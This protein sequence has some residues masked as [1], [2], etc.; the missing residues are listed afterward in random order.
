M[1]LVYVC[2]QYFKQCVGLANINSS[3]INKVT[4]LKTLKDRLDL[5]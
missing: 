3:S 4:F 5:K 2:M 1:S